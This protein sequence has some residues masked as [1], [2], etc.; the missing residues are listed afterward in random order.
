V[1]RRVSDDERER[2]TE[3]P[4]A[5]TLGRPNPITTS[6]RLVHD[7]V[8]DLAIYDRAYLLKVRR[9]DGGVGLVRLPPKVTAPGGDNWLM[10][11]EYVVAGARGTVTYLA[12]KVVDLH[13]Y[14]PDDSRTGVSPMET[15]RGILAEDAAAARYRSQLWRNG[16][17]IQGTIN[18]PLEAPEWGDPARDRFVEEFRDLY[19]G[20]GARA[21][22]V[23]ILED[24]M[25][26]TAS[27]YTAEQ[28]QYVE[29]RK[30]T[31]EEVAAAYF[32][33]PPMVGILE[34][35]TFSNITEQHKNLYQDTLGPWLQL[36]AQELELQLLPEYSDADRVYLEFNLAEKLRGSFEEQAA[37]MQTMVGAPVMSRNEGRSRLN[38][39]PVDGGDELV[40]PL[41]VL[42]GNRASPT[43]TA[44]PGEGQGEPPAG[45]AAAV[46]DATG[47][48]VRKAHLA[49]KAGGRLEERW[50]DK[51]A[52]VLTATFTRQRN[53]A[54]GA[55]AGK[56]KAD[57]G[58]VF[59]RLRWDR[60]LADDLL[61][62]SSGV[63]LAAAHK[64]LEDVGMD[65]ELVSVDGML[66]WLKAHAQ[67][68]ATGINDTTEASLRAALAEDD[69]RSSVEHV[70]EVALGMRVASAAATEV[71]AMSGFGGREGARGAG[72]TH[73]T[74][75]TT[76][77][78][79]RPTHARLNGVTIPVESLFANGAR[80]PGDSLL[81]DDEKA[82]CSCEVSFHR[83]DA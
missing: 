33:P 20:D 65:P 10:A 48:L 51:Y 39:P 4:A 69:P 21:G 52:Q 45:E 22:G 55:L 44:R 7:L 13:G 36:I 24:G 47:R 77:K 25:T 42:V 68:V 82:G 29:A 53:A 12:D 14:N 34:H 46:I 23:P 32:I 18:R 80:W 76:S 28:A 5:V 50:V 9:D 72:L 1:F 81:I 60:E 59:N 31:R 30:L 40:V 57:V 37:A 70:F 58:E 38:L 67:G 27:G 3:H 83:E 35:A 63:A 8:M 71:T 17:R 54:L 6:Y 74:W 41:N 19:S 26:F 62:V 49:I 56:A 66:A 61:S 2:L 11:T 43:D 75:R 16:A 79:P 73:K 64:V 15:L 78:N